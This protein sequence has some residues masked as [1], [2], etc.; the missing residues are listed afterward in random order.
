MV[1]AFQNA[2]LQ[3]IVKINISNGQ[4]YTPTAGT[5]AVVNIH[6]IVGSTAGV[7]RITGNGASVDFTDMS[8]GEKVSMDIRESSAPFPPGD[9]LLD[10]SMSITVS[11]GA[12][13]ATFQ[14]VALEFTDPT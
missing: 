9:I 5:F 10:D 7:A 4:S 8:S 2:P 14:G 13:S 3:R 6:R 12:P 1:T 11:G